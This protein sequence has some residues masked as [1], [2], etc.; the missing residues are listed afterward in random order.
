MM[1][2]MP[3]TRAQVVDR[4]LSQLANF[5]PPVKYAPSDAMPVP[6]AY[7]LD[8]SGRLGGDD[9]SAPLCA[10]WSYGYRVPTADCIGLALWASGLARKQKGYQGSLGEWLNTDSLVHDSE[11]GMK[12][13]RPLY[14]GEKAREGDWLITPSGY[15]LGVRTSIGHIGVIIRP[16]ASDAYEHLVVD[17]SPRHGRTTAVNTGGPWSTKCRVLRP[18]HYV[19]TSAP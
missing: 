1:Y 14:S 15:T 12:F 9:P 5:T 4:A 19:E 11:H 7:R 16:R 8:D 18:L 6:I 13:C 3:L 10:D 17:C 2:V